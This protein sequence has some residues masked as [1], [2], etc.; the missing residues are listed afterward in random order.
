MGDL[1]LTLKISRVVPPMMVG[2]EC[3][4]EAMGVEC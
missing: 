2:L 3:F 1:R 4:C